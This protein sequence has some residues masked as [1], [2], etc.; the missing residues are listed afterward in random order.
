MNKHLLDKYA[1][2]TSR[3]ADL[4]AASEELEKNCEEYLSLQ[5]A[6]TQTKP[7]IYNGKRCAGMLRALRK[8]N[9]QLQAIQFPTFR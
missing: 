4:I 9:P 8:L 2:I 1:R 5:A 3:L 7:T 6:R